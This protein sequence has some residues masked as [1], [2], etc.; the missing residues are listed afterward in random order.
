MHAHP[1]PGGAVSNFRSLILSV[2]HSYSHTRP[3]QSSAFSKTW[4]WKGHFY[5]LQQHLFKKQ[6]INAYNTHNDC[7]HFLSEAKFWS[8]KIQ[9]EIFKLQFLS[10]HLNQSQSTVLVPETNRSCG[11]GV[12][13][14][15]PLCS[16][17]RRLWP[18]SLWKWASSASSK[19][20]KEIKQISPGPSAVELQAVNSW[21]WNTQ[22]NGMGEIV[23]FLYLSLSVH[24]LPLS[25][26]VSP[27]PHPYPYLV[28]RAK[29]I[30]LKE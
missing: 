26:F 7:M 19:E 28:H 21:E 8:M 1:T 25:Q 18:A 2:T 10:I 30:H 12:R 23:I 22:W 9:T 5:F 3:V 29:L 13:A 24:N 17:V 6:N 14:S 20:E 16:P 27:Q 15:S 4:K 11:A